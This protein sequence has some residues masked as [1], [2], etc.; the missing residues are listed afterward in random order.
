MT[1][2]AN[3]PNLLLLGFP[4]C[5]TTSL[6]EWLADTPGIEVSN[7]K[8]TYR[9]CS[10]FGRFVSDDGPLFSGNSPIRVEASTLNVY[11]E[12]LKSR[13]RD[14][15]DL[16]AI[17]IFREPWDALVSWHNQMSNAGL[18]NGQSLEGCWNRDLSDAR[19][20]EYLENYREIVAYER[21]ITSWLD[22]LGHDRLL[23]LKMQ[24]LS[25]V[26]LSQRLIGNFL[27]VTDFPD[28]INKRNAYHKVRFAWI[29][30]MLRSGP[31]RSLIRTLKAKSPALN[32]LIIGVREKVFSG[33][34]HK[35][36][37]PK[38]IVQELAEPFA[39][40]VALLEQNRR[41]HGWRS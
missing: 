8:E 19:T 26:E 36:P 29:Y 20:P 21:H 30:D 12:N 7:P 33:K 6:A 2:I 10:E 22:L 4:K 31:M 25:D 11:S 1:D 24:E 41:V 32:K 5:G 15:P 13:V 27:Q 28:A 3:T 16:K 39:S 35:T 9:F 14:N 38:S 18:S 40:A 34:S 23:L 37:A 17:I